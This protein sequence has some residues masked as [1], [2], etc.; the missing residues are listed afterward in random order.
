MQN[1][2]VIYHIQI[3]ETNILDEQK[4]LASLLY[5]SSDKMTYPTSK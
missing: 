3:E 5:Y 2:H 1:V 4:E